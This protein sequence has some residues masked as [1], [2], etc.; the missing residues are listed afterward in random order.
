MHVFPGII[1]SDLFLGRV[2]VLLIKSKA[3]SLNLIFFLKPVTFSP[4]ELLI[5]SPNFPDIFQDL[6]LLVVIL[7]YDPVVFYERMMGNQEIAIFL[8][9]VVEI[10]L[11]VL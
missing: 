10:L 6:Y 4:T 1:F 3:G 9:C 11:S 2:S 8:E 7:P 5:I